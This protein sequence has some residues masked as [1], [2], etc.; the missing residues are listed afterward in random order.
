M[1]EQTSLLKWTDWLFLGLSLSGAALS[2]LLVVE[3]L[4]W[5]TTPGSPWGEALAMF[6][7][8]NTGVTFLL[9]GLGCLGIAKAALV[10]RSG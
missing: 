9:L 6:F 10:Y 8:E 4:G 2:I 7:Y 3:V 1:T 5:T